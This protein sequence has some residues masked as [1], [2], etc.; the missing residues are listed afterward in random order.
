MKRNLFL[1]FLLFLSGCVTPEET[2]TVF[3]DSNITA[4]VYIG[5]VKV[6]TT[7]YMDKLSGEKREMISLRKT[8]Y[9]TAKLPLKTIYKG[10]YRPGFFYAMAGIT[11]SN[12][13]KYL[14]SR[15]NFSSSIF[16]KEKREYREKDGIIQQKKYFIFGGSYWEDYNQGCI[17]TSYVSVVSFLLPPTA[18]TDALYDITNPNSSWVQYDRDSY[19]VEMIPE[20]KKAFTK[21]ELKQM[22]TR[23]MVLRTFNDL[24]LSSPEYAFALSRL[25]GK[26]FVPPAPD[27]SPGE[28]L[29]LIEK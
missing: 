20:N 10:N 25:T 12:C 18:T 19:F 22:R 1:V 2:K 11:S 16:D 8:G 5:D 4:D 9:K 26:P 6:G 3:I 21:E 14:Y 27:M 24:K 28:Y 15:T 29:R 7:P 17:D 23:L 13:N